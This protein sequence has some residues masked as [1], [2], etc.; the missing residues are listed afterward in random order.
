[1]KALTYRV[2]QLGRDLETERQHSADQDR[3]INAMRTVLHAW[4]Q[5]GRE[6]HEHWAEVRQNRYPP[7]LPEYEDPDSA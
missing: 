1:M 5:F 2:D 6:L 4:A 3:R 7:A